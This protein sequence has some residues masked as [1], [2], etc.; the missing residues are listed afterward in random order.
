MVA[1]TLCS[2]LL[3]SR[4]LVDELAPRLHLANMGAGPS[5]PQTAS[6]SPETLKALEALPEAARKE[7]AEAAAKKFGGGGAAPAAPPEEEDDGEGEELDLSDKGLV[8]LPKDQVYS[9]GLTQL[10]LYANKIKA[11]PDGVLGPLTKLK[12]LNC[13]NNQIKKLPGDIGGLGKLVEVN[14][15][16][17]KLMMTNDAQFASW[18]KVKV[19][20]LYDNNL[21][22]MG[23]L[24]PLKS[25]EELRIS[26]NNLEE[27]PVICDIC[28]MTIL[29][30]HKNRIAKVPDDFFTKTKALERL[31]I[32]GNQLTSLPASLLGCSA[33][34]GVQA[35]EMPL[36]SLPSGAWPAGMETL[37]V[38]ETK[39]TALPAELGVLDSLK[40]VNVGKLALDEPSVA[41]AEA[42]KAKIMAV[43]GGIFWGMDGVKQDSP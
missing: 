15:A 7:L 35:Q 9:T 22:R 40:R 29:E 19:L 11:I 1:G 37:F 32:W 39:V 25:L 27:M 13:F 38:Q 21:V 43:K 5:V 31:S 10:D 6:L 16:A 18:A 3:P 41:I 30:I 14:F 28:P 12:I 2:Q 4:V 34:V 20:N 24:A 26:G 17:N 42:I 8:E 23:S 36:E 33:L